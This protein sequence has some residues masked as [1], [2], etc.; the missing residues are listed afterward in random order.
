MLRLQFHQRKN[1]HAN[2]NIKINLMI[3]VI[4]EAS[5]NLVEVSTK[6]RAPHSGVSL[7]M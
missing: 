4:V 6:I 7:R 3:S 2:K 5:I 1:I